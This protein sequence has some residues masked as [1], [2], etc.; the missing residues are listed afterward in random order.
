MVESMAE[1]LVDAMVARM[2][3]KKA[4]GWVGHW[5]EMKAC[6]TVAMKGVSLAEQ[7]VDMMVS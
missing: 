3:G 1:H 2:V 4:V 6:E 7:R 5:A